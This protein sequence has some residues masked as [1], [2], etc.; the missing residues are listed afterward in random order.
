MLYLTV[1]IA[2]LFVIGSVMWLRPSPAEKRL[3]NLR[4]C[5]VQNGLRVNWLSSKDV[6]WMQSPS[7]SWVRYAYL[8]P[9]QRET[10]I[11]LRWLRDANGW[12]PKSHL[13]TLTSDF[14]LP[15]SVEAIEITAHDCAIVWR[16]SGSEDDVR[17]IAEALKQLAE[18]KFK[19]A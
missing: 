14:G 3:A 17:R 15:V 2:F 5:A 9:Q 12:Q 18:V 16:E 11:Q 13:Q 8:R 6:A 19:S 10:L 7:Q 4:Q 1:T